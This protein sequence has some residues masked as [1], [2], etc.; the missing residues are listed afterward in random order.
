MSMCSALTDA[1][2]MFHRDKDTIDT[3]QSVEF[4][5][6]LGDIYDEEVKK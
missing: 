3:I 2:A 6:S 4:R 5:E 1:T